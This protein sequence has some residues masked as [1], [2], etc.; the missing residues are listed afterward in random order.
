MGA[1]RVPEHIWR[2]RDGRLVLSG[3]PDAAFLAY[4]RG[5][6][7]SEAEA[8]RRGILDAVAGGQARDKA[9][10]QAAKP[11]LTI[12]KAKEPTNG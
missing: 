8:R 2:T 4:A 7:M 1:F 11:G 10:K 12:H 3:H 6:E 9:P 5:D